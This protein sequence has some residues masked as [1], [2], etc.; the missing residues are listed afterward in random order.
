MTPNSGFMADL[1][2]VRFPSAFPWS[3]VFVLLQAGDF[4]RNGDSCTRS[5]LAIRIKKGIRM[6]CWKPS[7]KEHGQI[8]SDSRLSGDVTRAQRR[9]GA[10]V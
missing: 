7:D 2:P 8:H 4:V 9:K 3:A 5:H 10:F 1:G 6:E